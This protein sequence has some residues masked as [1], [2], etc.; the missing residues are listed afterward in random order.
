MSSSENPNEVTEVASCERG[1]AGVLGVVG[2]LG[3]EGS[4]VSSRSENSEESKS[5]L[6]GMKGRS[7]GR[8]SAISSISDDMFDILI[9]YVIFISGYNIHR[10]QLY[11]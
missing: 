8:N 1:V 6:I 10:Y 3:V 7:M 2:V 11:I 5:E 9:C 4:V